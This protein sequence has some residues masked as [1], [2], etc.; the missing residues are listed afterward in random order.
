VAIDRLGSNERIVMSISV[1]IRP[2]AEGRSVRQATAGGNA[3]LLRA[4]LRANVECGQAQVLA[5]GALADSLL[6]TAGQVAAAA[7]RP[8]FDV[9]QELNRIAPAGLAASPRRTR[10]SVDDVARPSVWE[11]DTTTS[12]VY[13]VDLPGVA[14]ADDVLVEVG[15]ASILIDARRAA[16]GAEPPVRYQTSIWVSDDA[17]LRSVTAELEHGVLHVEV[18]RREPTRGRRVNVSAGAGEAEGKSRPESGTKS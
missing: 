18:A 17:D 5:M 10:R 9:A 14:V 1:P 2:A 13:S 7:R 6:G 11:A 8:M 12:Y 15:D 4:L 16:R 3:D